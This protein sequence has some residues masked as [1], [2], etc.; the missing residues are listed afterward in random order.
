LTP[1]K[2]HSFSDFLLYGTMASGVYFSYKW[3]IA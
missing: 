3:W 2:G 1:R